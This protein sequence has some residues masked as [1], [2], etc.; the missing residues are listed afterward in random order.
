MKMHTKKGKDG[1]RIALIFLFL[2]FVHI[3]S[4]KDI[5]ILSLGAKP[6]GSLNTK[7]IQKAIDQVSK[8]GGGKVIIPKGIFVSGSLFFKSGVELHVSKGATLLGSSNPYDYR[9]NDQN[10]NFINAIEVNDIS[11]TGEGTLNGQGRIVALAIDS[12]HH[13]DELKSNGYNYRRS[14]PNNRPF[15]IYMNRCKNILVEGVTITNAANWVSRYD[16]CENLKINNIKVESTTYWNNDGIDI[17]DCKDVILT[18]SF[19]NAADDGI[20]LKSHEKDYY[21]DNIYIAN[22]VVRSSASAI[23][24]GT[25]SD[26]GF[27]NVKIENITIY[28]TFRS[29]IALESVDGGVLENIDINNVVATNTGNGIFIRLGHRNIDGKVGVLRNVTIKNLRV[30]IPFEQ[31][32]L[33]YDC[34]GPELSFFHNPFPNSIT[35]IE[36]HYVE[37]VH[38]ENITI[39]HPGRASKGYAQMPL[40][41]IAGIPENEADYPEFHM[42]GELPSWGFYVRHVKGLTFKNVN[43]KLSEDDFRPA[44]VFDD[45]SDLKLDG[46]TL[47]PGR[48][49]DQ[50][51]FWNVTQYEIKNFTVDGEEIATPMILKN[52]IK[53]KKAE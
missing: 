23:K 49:G 46:V 34:R 12:L 53:G 39:T 31:P 44:M 2:L 9:S 15:L 47:E 22:C 43:L 36:G 28:D 16:L 13:I 14:R 24:F 33:Y 48:K 29:A 45:V 27:K 42:F 51:A 20:C 52:V 18:N 30:E 25:A 19:I 32:D 41:R 37:N 40:Y 3:S 26:G 5:N 21:N 1:I 7:I 8:S 4:G 10:K 17:S 11:I 50:I 35:G 38:L 6:D